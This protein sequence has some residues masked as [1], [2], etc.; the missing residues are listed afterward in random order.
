MRPLLEAHNDLRDKHCA[1]PL[2]WSDKLAR[3]AQRWVDG[4][5]RRGCALEHSGGRYGENLA[6]GSAGA[7]GPEEVAEMWYDEGERYNFKRGGFSM[8]TGHFTQLVWRSSERLGCGMASCRGLEIWVCNYDPAGNVE[9]EY[10]DNVLPTSC[11][12]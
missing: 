11:K 6:G 8:N 5:A 4:L 9:G 3:I 1:P 12:R 2:A 10:R 7:L